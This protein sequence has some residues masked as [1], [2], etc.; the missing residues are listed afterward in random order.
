MKEHE[1]Q[2]LMMMQQHMQEM[3][4]NKGGM[5]GMGGMK[6]GDGAGGMNG[7][8]HG[9]TTPEP[10]KANHRHAT[11]ETPETLQG[12]CYRPDFCWFRDDQTSV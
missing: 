10:A 9:N 1:K 2:H 12:G 3:M 4:K 5:G 7:M 6:H 11:L 8:Q